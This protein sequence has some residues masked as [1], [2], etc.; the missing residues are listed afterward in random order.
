MQIVNLLDLLRRP[1]SLKPVNNKKQIK[2][3][4]RR[5]HH[6]E[7]RYPRDECCTDHGKRF[8]KNR[9]PKKKSRRPHPFLSLLPEGIPFLLGMPVRVQHLS[10]LHA[11]KLMGNVMQRYNLAVSGLRRTKRLRQSV[12]YQ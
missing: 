2:L 5:S 9:L 8:I 10:E 4:D 7:W 12:K 1:I 11:G 6:Y 3:E